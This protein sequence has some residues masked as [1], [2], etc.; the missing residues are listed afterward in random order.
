MLVL[1]RVRVNQCHV[2][3]V[4]ERQGVFHGLLVLCN[5]SVGTPTVEAVRTNVCGKITIEY[6]VDKVRALKKK[7]MKPFLE[8]VW[9]ATP[10]VYNY[11]SI[12]TENS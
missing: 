12:N 4:L 7:K 3:L 5:V 6:K 2:R 10:K 8:A 11:N 9:S 1:H